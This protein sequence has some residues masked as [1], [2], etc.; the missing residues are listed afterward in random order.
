MPL[1]YIT[2]GISFIIPVL[3]LIM[4]T[5]FAGTT[6]DP[7]TGA[8]TTV[9]GFT[10]VWQAFGSVGGAAFAAGLGAVSVVVLNKTALV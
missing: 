9:E 5:M 1:V 4:T 7:V 8:E 3:I 2:T 6:T 10:N